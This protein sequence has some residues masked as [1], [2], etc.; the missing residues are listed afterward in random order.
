MKQCE[1]P[2]CVRHRA[3]SDMLQALQMIS[4]EIDLMGLME[5]RYRPTGTGEAELQWMVRKRYLKSNDRFRAGQTATEFMTVGVA[6]DIDAILS[7]LASHDSTEPLC[8]RCGLPISK[9]DSG[10]ILE[11]NSVWHATCYAGIR[12]TLADSTEKE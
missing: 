5:G 8:Q 3:G 9:G 10:V 11:D 6:R 7:A 2:D 1:C 4:K 12:P